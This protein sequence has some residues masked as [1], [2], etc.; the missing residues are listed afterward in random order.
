M[1]KFEFAQ[2]TPLVGVTAVTA[3]TAGNTVKPKKCEEVWSL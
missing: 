3:V 2:P 1:K